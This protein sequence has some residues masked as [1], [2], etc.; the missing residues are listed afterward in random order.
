LS[1]YK[2]QYMLTSW[3]DPDDSDVTIVSRWDQ[4]AGTNITEQ[5]FHSS[6]PVLQNR[7]PNAVEPERKKNL[8]HRGEEKRIR[9]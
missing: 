8:N 1:H 7:D 3:A 2:P 5:G 9:E 6:G 4:Q